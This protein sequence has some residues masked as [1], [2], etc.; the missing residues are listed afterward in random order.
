[1]SSYRQISTG[2]LLFQKERVGWGQ[3]H[4]D[5][6]HNNIPDLLQL[7]IQA[8][9]IIIERF[10]FQ[11]YKLRNCEIR[12]TSNLILFVY[13]IEHTSQSTLIIQKV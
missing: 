1:M 12:A 5:N 11:K 8:T 2:K 10:S 6:H 13:T 4:Q 7:Y 9:I 3:N